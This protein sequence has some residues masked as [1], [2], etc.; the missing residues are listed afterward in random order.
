MSITG[1]IYLVFFALLGIMGILGLLSIYIYIRYG[2]SLSI[3]MG[4]SAV[5]V[6]LFIIG[7]VSALVSLQNLLGLYAR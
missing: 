5:F 6:V 1:I 4:S 7:S 3:T 2:R